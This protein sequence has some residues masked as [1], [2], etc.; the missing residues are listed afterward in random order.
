MR[1]CFVAHD[2]TPFNGYGRFSLSLIQALSDL[3]IVGPILIQRKTDTPKPKLKY[4]SVL[5]HSP[6]NPLSK[7]LKL[8]HDIFTINKWAKDCDL[9]HL[10]TEAPLALS[11][12]GFNK[13]YI[14]TAHGTWTIRPLEANVI[15]RTVFK[16]AYKKAQA[17]VAVSQ[18]TKRLL[19]LYISSKKLR[20]IHN[21]II[22]P[23]QSPK[24]KKHRVKNTYMVL[25][26]GALN[27]GKDYLTSI[28]AV[29]KAAKNFK[30]LHYTIVSGRKNS[31]I[32]SLLMKEAQKHD[33]H[34]LKIKA[35]HGLPII[36]TKSGAVTEVVG[37]LGSGLL[38]KE[39]DVLKL[40]KQI[41][42]LLSKPKR[43]EDLSQKGID[44]LE[45]FS[46]KRMAMEY[47]SLYREIVSTHEN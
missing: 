39:G 21:G 7:P 32:Q 40:A 16:K 22:F 35:A 47:R 46:A 43:Y 37:M 34:N 4:K 41:K 44:Q 1:V 12:F 30:A 24:P 27:R 28:R 20:T 45:Y 3:N 13:P 38:A 9:I 18:F 19:N 14:V 42:K 2:L 5:T 11:V 15:S 10:L 26:V 8:L 33:F 25:S 17:V 23:K 6:T 29:S 36:A 31:A